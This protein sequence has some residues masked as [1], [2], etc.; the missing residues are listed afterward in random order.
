MHDRGVVETGT[1]LTPE[2]TCACTRMDP[3]RMI[4]GRESSVLAGLHRYR[5]SDDTVASNRRISHAGPSDDEGRLRHQFISD[6]DSKPHGRPARPLGRGEEERALLQA[7]QEAELPFQG[8]LQADPDR[9]ALRH[10]QARRLGR[11]PGGVPGRLVSGSA[12]AHVAERQGHRRGRSARGRTARS[13]AWTSGT[14][15]PSRGS[16]PSWAT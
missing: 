4:C 2:S 7:R 13:S 12:G 9:R 10:L 5:H 16:R 8:I 14:S 1:S 11:R 3:R 6:A 15:S